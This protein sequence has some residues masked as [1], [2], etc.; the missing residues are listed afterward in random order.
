MNEFLFASKKCSASSGSR[1][2]PHAARTRIR[3]PAARIIPEMRAGQASK[4]LSRRSSRRVVSLAQLTILP[5]VGSLIRTWTNL[6]ETRSRRNNGHGRPHQIK[7]SFAAAVNAHPDSYQGIAFR[8]AVKS[9]QTITRVSADPNW[10]NRQASGSSQSI[11]MTLRHG[12]KSRALIRIKFNRDL[13]PETRHKPY[14]GNGSGKLARAYPIT[15]IAAAFSRS[16]CGTILS[17]V[18]AAVW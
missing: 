13:L 10:H 18:S 6:N 4:K 16:S 2:I 1:K 9:H 12:W 14:L 11:L 15:A 7:N 8:H 3:N 17:S 5:C